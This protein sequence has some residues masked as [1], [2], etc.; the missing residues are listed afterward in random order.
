MKFPDN[1][2]DLLFGL[3][4]NCIS[5]KEAHESCP[6]RD[7]R[8]NLSIEEKYQYA[9]GLNDAEVKNILAQHEEC[10]EKLHKKRYKPLFI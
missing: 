10:Y 3:L 2:R 4:L 1:D 6:L 9:L 7:L 8:N 5:S